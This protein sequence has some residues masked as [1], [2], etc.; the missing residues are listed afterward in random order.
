MA[1]L[2]LLSPLLA[3]A[4][5]YVPDMGHGFIK[6]DFRWIRESSVERVPDALALLLSDNGFYRPLVSLSFALDHALFGTWPFGYALTN[7]LLILAAALALYG[8]A[9]GLGLS[10]G[11]AAFAA[12]ALLLNPHGV[13]DAILWISGRTSGLLLLLSLLAGLAFVRGRV[14]LAAGGVFL[15]LLSKE[16]AIL[17]PAV[18][19]AW[20]GLRAEG[21]LPQ[22]LRLALVRSWP[23]FLPLPLYL[24]LRSFTHAY[25][26]GTAPAHYRFGLEPALLA[27]NLLEY[28]DRACLFTFLTLVVLALAVRRRPRLEAGERRVLLWS[29]AWIAGG[30]GLTLWL[31]VR[32]SLY[33]LFP[34]AGITTRHRLQ[35]YL[36]R[37]YLDRRRARPERCDQ[38]AVAGAV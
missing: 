31:P 12:A 14:W 24:A 18:L 13:K 1:R 28:A 34:S 3:F 37:G 32:S 6:D 9:R 33:A 27:R 23:L 30:Y 22:R 5:A 35:R 36:R 15:A 7:L 4:L 19:A 38:L 20:A 11:A 21:D 25:L 17:L 2:L 26:P 29:L 8:L 10:A 16:E